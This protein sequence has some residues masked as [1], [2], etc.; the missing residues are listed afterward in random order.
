MKSDLKR[1]FAL[2]AATLLFSLSVPAEE[3]CP[4]EVKLLLPP[5]TTQLVISSLGFG[6]ETAGRVYLFDTDALELSMQG[7]IVRVRQG[8]SNDLT[9][10]VR[11]PK[12]DRQVDRSQLRGRFPC[13]ID[14]TQAEAITSYAVRRRYEAAKVP[15]LGSEIYTLLSA[16]QKQLLH[17]AQA[18]I[19]WERVSRIANINSTQWVTKTASPSG[20][21][22]LELWEWQAGKILEISAKSGPATAESAYAELERLLKLKSLSLSASQDTKTN[23]VLGTLEAHDLILHTPTRPR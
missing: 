13:E 7:I 10:K 18:S 21:L 6:Q 22:S 15:E 23:L 3:Q 20:K 17:E 11:P 5:P 16:S 9:V 14:R 19:D 1:A 4:V 8:A 12:G 2:I